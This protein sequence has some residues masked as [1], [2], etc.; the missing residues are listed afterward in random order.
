MPFKAVVVFKIVYPC[1][2]LT[3][4]PAAEMLRF[5]SKPVPSAYTFTFEP[6]RIQAVPFRHRGFP[7]ASLQG[8][9]FSLVSHMG[10]CPVSVHVC[11]LLGV[12]GLKKQVKDFA[13]PSASRI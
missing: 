2:L 11:R 1:E 12:M 4:M 6:S 8:A 10:G 9:V 13:F 5:R 3:P 7:Y